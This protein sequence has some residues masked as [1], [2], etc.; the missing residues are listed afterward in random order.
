MKIV[1]D[2]KNLSVKIPWSM[3]G[4]LDATL[5]VFFD[6]FSKIVIGASIMM[7]VMKMP[8]SFVFGKIIAAIGLAALVMLSWNTIMARWCG[9]KTNNPTITALPGG[10]AAGTFFVW[11]NAIMIPVYLSTGDAVMAWKV[12][13]L[14]NIFHATFTF[15][16]A[17]IID[18]ILKYIP[19]Q[20][21]FSGLVGGSLAWLCMSSLAEGFA[22]PAIIIPSLFVLLTMYFAKIDSKKLSPAIVGIGVGTIIAW[23]TGAMNSGA[24][25]ESFKTLGIYIALPQFKFLS[26][27]A[28]SIAIKYLPIILAFAFADVIGGIQAVEQAESGGDKYSR[29]TALIGVACV[30]FIGAILGNPFVM[31]YYWGHPAWKKAKAGASY[32]MYIGIL[33]F[34]LCAT[35]LVA[36][37]TS[38]L[39]AAATMILII[40]AGLSSCAQAFEV[41]KPKYY[42]AMAIGVAIPIFELIYGKIN[43]GIEGAKIAIGEALKTG[44]IDFA[45]SNVK[46]SADHLASAGLAK[47]FLPLSQGSMLIAIIYV[48]ALCFITDRKWIGASMSFLVASGCSFIGLIHS[49]SVMINAA[50][51]YSLIYIILSAA[52]LIMNFVFKNNKTEE[53]MI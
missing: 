18:S 14:A 45:V 19:S 20:A 51:T 46:V 8:G 1:Q 40:Y 27:D 26:G 2:A 6:G 7:G 9:S 12:G 36:I 39:P 3:P 28:I 43:S 30:N 47:G 4:D 34:I 52:F 23:A 42:P 48:A 35:G 41:N 17:F 11:I 53:V 10:I 50:P 37:A 31:A 22:T 49:S 24:V 32:T 29:R 5:G 44:G 15:I 33:Y 16:S 38:V 21:I 13:I 25:A